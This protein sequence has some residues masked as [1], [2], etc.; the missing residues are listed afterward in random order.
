MAA[1]DYPNQREGLQEGGSTK[2]LGP[3]G[4][5]FC[6]FTVLQPL[7]GVGGPVF[8]IF[9]MRVLRG[10]FGFYSCTGAVLG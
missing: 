3:G 9:I 6:S 10:V 5:Q 8:K 1:E 7:Y 4:V 2:E